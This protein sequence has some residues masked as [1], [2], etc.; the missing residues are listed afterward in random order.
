VAAWESLLVFPEREKHE[1]YRIKGG[2]KGEPG[3]SI[4]HGKVGERRGE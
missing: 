3:S 2:S 4:N 1:S